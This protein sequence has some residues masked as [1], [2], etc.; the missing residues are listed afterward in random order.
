MFC[1]VFLQF[2]WRCQ[3]HKGLLLPQLWKV[4]FGTVHSKDLI[5]PPHKTDFFFIGLQSPS[6]TYSSHQPSVIAPQERD[7]HS[8]SLCTE[9]G[10][11]GPVL[12]CKRT[13]SD[14]WAVGAW[15]STHTSWA[16]AASVTAPV[17]CW[18]Q[19]LASHLINPG[20]KPELA[21][22]SN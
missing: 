21:R 5:G 18:Y 10:G 11:R 1:L 20:A 12:A 9:V 22:V 8:H 2:P 14:K 19:A 16:R 3:S 4:T 15:G 6:S 17:A 13:G 7:Q